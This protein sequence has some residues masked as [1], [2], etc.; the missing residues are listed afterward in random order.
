MQPKQSAHLANAAQLELAQTDPLF[1]PA[2]HLLDASAGV[3]RL[4][5]ALAGGVLG[6][7]RR[8]AGASPLADKALRVVP[9]VGANSIP[10]GLGFTSQQF[11]WIRP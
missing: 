11:V 7:M 4:G 8:D 2:K 6:H 1:D 9:L 5:L 10:I 3:D